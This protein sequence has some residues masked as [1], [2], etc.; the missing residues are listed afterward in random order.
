[1]SALIDD[2]LHLSR[3]SRVEIN[4]EPVDL[5]APYWAEGAVA[6]GATFYFTLPAT[7]ARP[8]QY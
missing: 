8:G 3:V 6:A 7:Q 4:P 1:M 2:L 5:G